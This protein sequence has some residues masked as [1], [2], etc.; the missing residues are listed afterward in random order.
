MA[1][2]W[3]AKVRR[4]PTDTIDEEWSVIAPVVL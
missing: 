3:K 1:V 2:T 4:S